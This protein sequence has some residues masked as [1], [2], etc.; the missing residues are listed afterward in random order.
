[1][2]LSQPLLQSKIP[3]KCLKS[4]IG[5]DFDYN[6]GPSQDNMAQQSNWHCDP[7]T[8]L[9]SVIYFIGHTLHLPKKKKRKKEGRKRRT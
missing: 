2:S 1:M 4:K 3:K 6:F 7:R 5:T 8:R 9:D